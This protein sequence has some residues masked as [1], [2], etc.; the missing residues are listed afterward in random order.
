MHENFKTLFPGVAISMTV[1]FAASFL[2]QHY[3]APAM[4]FALLLG[5]ALN[6]L[7]EDDK[8]TIGIVVSSKTVLRLGVALLGFRIAFQDVT[9][10]GINTV[11]LLIV[12]VAST[13]GIGIVLARAFGLKHRFGALTG[14]AVAICGASAAL[15][16]S[17][18]MPK[19]DDKPRDTAFA[20]IG[21][22]T[23]STL[24]M[25]I[26]PI[27]TNALDLSDRD[28]GI[29]LGA[30]IHDV[31]QVVGAGYSISTEAG[32]IATLTKLIR[33]SFLLPVV[34]CILFAFRLSGTK[35]NTGAKAPLLPSFLVAFIVFVAINSIITIPVGVTDAINGF[36]RFCLITAIAAIGLKTNLRSLAEVGMKPVFLMVAQTLWL[37]ALVIIALTML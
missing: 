4:L 17:A 3:G 27:I 28:A 5:M 21:V 8:C 34:M 15:A 2:S 26:Y 24:A 19:T 25:I 7:G 18:A 9:A 14:G 35:S 20:V 1:G 13:I 10:L 33:V 6:F 29:F 11:L 12:A 36:S 32:D 23:L 16:I 37:A 22:T 31:A 30:T